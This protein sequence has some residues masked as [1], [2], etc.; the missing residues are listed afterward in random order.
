MKHLLPNGQNLF[1]F[2]LTILFIFN[3]TFETN[4]Q[5]RRIP[6]KNPPNQTRKLPK[7]GIVINERLSV[8]RFEPSLLSIPLQRLSHG[9]ELQ[10]LSEREIEGVKF[11][12]VAATNEKTGWMQAE[13]VILPNRKGED[14]RLAR[15]IQVSDGFEQL[16]RMNIFL[17]NFPNSALRPPILLLFGDLAEGTAQKLSTD[18]NRRLDASEIRA[19]GASVRSWFLNYNG[20]DR[21]RRQGLTFLFNDKTRKF[22]YNGASWQEILKR[23]PKSNEAGEAQKRIDSLKAKM[24]KG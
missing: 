24:E 6:S 15:L 3:F 18:A 11:Y 10:I 19:S 8:L 9:R 20:L 14:E 17:E 5:K 22:H 7:T 1:P 12:R 2:F 4:A 13:A 21:Y 16:E 23:F